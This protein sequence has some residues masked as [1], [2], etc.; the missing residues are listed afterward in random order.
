VIIAAVEFEGASV[1]KGVELMKVGK[2]IG[3]RDGTA[4]PG[5]AVQDL[6]LVP[7]RLERGRKIGQADRLGPNGGL[8]KILDGWLYKEDFHRKSDSTRSTIMK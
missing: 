3:D 4:F 8:I 1:V 6:Y 7:L 5:L 2:F